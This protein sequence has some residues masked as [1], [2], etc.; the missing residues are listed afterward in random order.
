M[1]AASVVGVVVT[2]V[3]KVVMFFLLVVIGVM[4]IGKVME[5][6]AVVMAQS[7]EQKDHGR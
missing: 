5:V 6:I 1:T 2:V 3:I 7:G 4:V